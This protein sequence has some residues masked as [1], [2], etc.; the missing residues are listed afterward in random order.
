MSSFLLKKR[1]PQKLDKTKH[2]L[3]PVIPLVVESKS[4]E[5]NDKS[6]FITVE[7]KA[8]AGTPADAA[9]CKKNMCTFEEG[10]PQEWVN[11]IMDAKE[12]WTQNS[13]NGMTDRASAF[14]SI[15]KGESLT[16][17]D[18]VLDEVHRKP[19]AEAGAPLPPISEQHLDEATNA[20]A[21]EV[22]PHC[23]L[24]IQ[25][26]WMSR[27]MKKPFKL[28]ARKTAAAITHLNNV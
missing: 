3:Q 24:E 23:A 11:L 22:F 1:A 10:T 16:A 18:A 6:K 27:G 20:V 13:I 7:L 5:D 28:S 4:E 9:K 8:R 2:A 21:Q 15:L 14:C 12:I 25:K 17:F 26:L 19:G